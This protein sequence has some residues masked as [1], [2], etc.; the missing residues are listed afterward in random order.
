MRARMKAV[1]ERHEHMLLADIWTRW[2]LAA[3]AQG[4]ERIHD[5]HV[6][7]WAVMK[8]KG[9]M[10]QVRAMEYTAD[11][12][13]ERGDGRIVVRSWDRWRWMSNLRRREMVMAQEVNRRVLRDWWASW[14]KRMWVS[15]LNV[16]VR[17]A[18][19]IPRRQY[20]LASDF[21]DHV[22][23]KNGLRSWKTSCDRI[24]VSPQ[25]TIFPVPH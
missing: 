19:P 15:F 21:Y 24:R 25:C 23:L 14:K 5:V 17:C 9:K 10:S 2:K 13:D 6:L 20:Q 8:W 3:R 12:Y 18:H 4:A 16:K 7:E 1:R 11:A 22:C